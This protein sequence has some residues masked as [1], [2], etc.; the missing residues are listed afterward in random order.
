MLPRDRDRRAAR[1]RLAAERRRLR[2]AR[3]ADQVMPLSFYYRQRA[4]LPI[5]PPG[6]TRCPR[7]CLW[8][9]PWAA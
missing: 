1:N 8:C 7:S 2:H 3:L 4:G 6:P 9:W 5:V